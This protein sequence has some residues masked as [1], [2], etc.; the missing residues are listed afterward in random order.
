[1][2]LCRSC[3]AGHFVKMVHN[4][5]EYGIMQAYAEGFNILHGS[6]MLVP[7]TLKRV[8][9]KSL[10]WIVQRTTVM[11]L[12]LLKSLSVGEGKWCRC[13]VLV[14]GPYCGCTTPRWWFSKFAGGSPIVGKVVGLSMLLWTLAYPLLSSVAR[15]GHVLSRAVLVFTF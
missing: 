1:M 8:M 10:Q 7:N 11:T 15:C 14:T 2:D 5:I 6:S 4:G 13:W 9:L 3:S 12:T